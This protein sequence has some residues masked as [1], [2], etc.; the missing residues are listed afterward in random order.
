MERYNFTNP[1]FLF[2]IES[3]IRRFFI[4]FCFVLLATCD[5]GDIITVDLD[6]DGELERCD[7]DTDSYL[8]YDTRT[9]PNESLSLIIERDETNELLFTEA[10]D[11]NIPTELTIDGTTTVSYTHLTLP[12]TSRV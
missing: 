5:D 2:K 10:T 12:T 1:L 6:F 8:I 9:S 7:N 4:I 11:E 3:M